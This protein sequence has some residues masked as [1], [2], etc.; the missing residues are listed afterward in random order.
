M[1]SHLRIRPDK[2]IFDET[3]SFDM[4][5]FQAGAVKYAHVASFMHFSNLWIKR[6]AL[7]S[8]LQPILG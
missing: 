4:P 8:P 5:L 1:S 6:I 7:P 2:P 3:L